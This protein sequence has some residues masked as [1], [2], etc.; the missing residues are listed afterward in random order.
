MCSGWSCTVCGRNCTGGWADC[1]K[2][3]SKDICFDCIDNNCICIECHIPSELILHKHIIA[4]Y[5]EYLNKEQL[6]W[7]K[8]VIRHVTLYLKTLE[9]EWKNFLA[10]YD[11]AEFDEDA[12]EASLKENDQDF[13]G[14]DIVEE[15]VDNI[16][17]FEKE[18]FNVCKI[19]PLR[20]A[21]WLGK[22]PLR[23]QNSEPQRQKIISITSILNKAIESLQWSNGYEYYHHNNW[24]H[25]VQE[26]EGFDF[27]I[28]DLWKLIL[29]YA[30]P[31]HSGTE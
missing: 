1:R 19:T 9:I 20:K 29:S 4:A 5:H 22:I 12:F 6:T 21:T 30:P 13:K 31:Q 15:D 17:Y 24:C 23:N 18:P 28:P 2:C 11:N 25:D 27:L 10:C 7:Q 3:K 8:C 16:N 14:D 26:V